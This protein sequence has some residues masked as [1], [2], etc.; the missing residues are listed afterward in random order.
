MSKLTSL[1]MLSILALGITSA[2]ALAQSA[3][4]IIEGTVTD[5]SGAVIPNATV[6]I[7]NKADNGLRTVT[8]NAAG[9]YSA[10]ALAPGEYSVRV[11]LTGFKTVVRDATVNAGGDISVN[12]ALSVGE[13]NEVVNVEA[14]SA[15]IN[16]E[17]NTV[18]GVIDRAAV[19]DLPLNGR[20]FMQLAVLEP[21]VTI[22]SGSTSQYNALFT[23]SVLGAGNRTLFTA[24]GGNITDHIDTGGGSAGMN[25]SQDVIQEFQLSSVNFDLATGISSGGAINIVTRSGSNE[26]HGSG[27]FY[28][29]D[30]NIAAYP[31]LQRQANYPNPFFARRNPGFTIGGPILK[32]KLFFFF[33]IEHTNQVQASVT[34]PNTTS[35]AALAGIYNSP[36]VGTQIT[37]RFDYHLSAKN[38]LFARYSHDG[39]TGYGPVGATEANPSNWVRNVNW[40]D[41][42]IIGLTTI[43][44]A[45][46]VNDA[47]FEYFY[48]SNHNLQS[49]PSD[50][51][52]PTCI[53]GGLPALLA[54]IGT[55][56]GYGV[57]G[58]EVGPNP[59]APQTR[60]TRRY[61]L[62]DSLNWQLGDHRV[63]FG[64]EMNRTGN[65]GQWGFCTPYCEG[66]FGPGQI[67]Q[68]LYGTSAG[69]VAGATFPTSLASNADFLNSPFYSLATGIFTGIG[70]GP[71]KQPAPYDASQGI[72]EN[73]FRLFVQDTWKL[74]PNLTLNA[75]IAWNAQTGYF[76]PLAQP[77]F[78]APILG[79]NNL[80]VTPNNLKEFSPAVGFAYSPGKSGKTVIRGGG[81]IYY[82][83]VPGYYHNRTPASVGPLGDARS[84]LSTQ[85]FTNIFPGILVNGVPLAIGAPIPVGAVTNLTLGQ[86]NQIYN[87][88]IAAIT[89]KLSPVPPTS[90]PY[91]V[92]GID[93][94]KSGI[95]IFPPHYPIARS[96]QISI[97][98]QRELG[99]GLVLSADYAMRQAE[100]LSQGELDY[101]LNSR[102][103]NGV[104]TPVI[105]TCTGA[106]LFVVG[107]ECSTGAITFWTPEGRSRYNGLLMKLSK[108]MSHRY[109]YTVSYQLAENR[110]DTAVWNLLNYDASYGQTLPR[111]TLNVAGMALLPWGFELTTNA[112]YIGLVPVDPVISSLYLPG[113]APSGSSEPI[114][115]LPFDCFAITCSKTDLANAVA[116]FNTT[117]AGTKGANG[118]VIPSLVLPSNYR[119][120]DS[121][122]T[123]DFALH[124]TF[125][126][127]ER[128]KL[129]I[130]GQVFNAFNIANL[131]GFSY[132]L[133]VKNA[134]PALQTYAFGQ[135]TSRAAQTFGSAGPRAFQFAARISF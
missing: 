89:A 98:A 120:G 87:Q 51:V 20:S 85:A 103:I 53:G 110:A 79:A 37:T 28:Y 10:P 84:T 126:Y 112:S 22:S 47:R 129:L 101:N 48:W 40:A 77:Q 125:T 58:A 68:T 4:G 73:Q 134:N 66:I 94:A 54:V 45:K 33:N 14:A 95:E 71:S 65:T 44:N 78:L 62:T 74:R 15:Q 2:P 106:Q 39:N 117:Y 5:A 108:R 123:I 86:F 82:D 59:N 105:P 29:R 92:S 52:Q 124:K 38:T 7:T 3:N 46:V 61:D 96:Y 90:G 75:G 34:Q 27:Y 35:T 19:A 31:G 72:Y 88:Q 97:G 9:A 122:T 21:G 13:T 118:N 130:I 80:G 102:Y 76:T 50:C 132:T 24:D 83:A 43:I 100:N 121:T 26:F 55:N 70:V 91:T 67:A 32:D 113:T 16:Y 11:E 109:Q 119:L 1:L 12:L 131:G 25:L 133:D 93:V 107:Q 104:Q 41:Q 57:G 115:G 17:S 69:G 49:L 63:K 23:V 6:T 135:A 127:K 60:N 56:I 99:G 116:S 8:T 42:S 36:Y 111:Q 64:G 30:H 81:G 128:Y 114:P 18:Q